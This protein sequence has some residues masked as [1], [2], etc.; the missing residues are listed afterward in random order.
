MHITPTELNDIL[1]SIKRKNLCLLT[2]DYQILNEFSSLLVLFAEATSITQ[3][4]NIPSISFIAP[5]VS[6]IYYDLLNEK[7]N[8]LFTLPLCEALL[9]SLPAR[10][11]GLLEELGIDVD[12]KIKIKSSSELYQDL[13][14]IYSTFLD[15]KIKLD[16]IDQSLLSLE[17]KKNLREKNQ[18]VGI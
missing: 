11:G 6:R 18:K 14:F 8:V 12:R 3:A 2:K 4:E 7:S 1:I 5:T 13:I 16:W 17:K 15:G 9:S 10:F